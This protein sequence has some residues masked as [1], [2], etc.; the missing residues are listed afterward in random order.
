MLVEILV[1]VILII[2]FLYFSGEGFANRDEKAHAIYEW[3]KMGHPSYVRYKG[4]FGQQSNIVEYSDV[5]NLPNLSIS[6][7]RQII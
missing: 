3:F 5:K 6:A 4:A 7:V 1:I 2:S